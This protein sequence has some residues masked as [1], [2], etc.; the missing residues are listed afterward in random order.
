MKARHLCAV[1]GVAVAVGTVVF[2]RSL[3]ATNDHQSLARAESLLREV[4]VDAKAETAMLT[5]DYRPNGRVMQGR[6][7]S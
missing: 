3:V 2:M 6:R 1:A 4:P 5:L 7:S